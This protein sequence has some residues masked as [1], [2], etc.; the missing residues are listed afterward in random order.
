MIDV[1][2]LPPPR[3]RNSTATTR[4]STVTMRSVLDDLDTQTMRYYRR[5][6]SRYDLTWQNIDANVFFD[7][8]V[9][10]PPPTPTLTLN[11]QFQMAVRQADWCA[12]RG[13]NLGRLNAM[14]AANRLR[15]QIIQESSTSI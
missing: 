1:A 9:A 2:N 13:D 4:N 14:S 10:P 6:T 15:R 11:E 7:V 12:Q 8:P 5:V 3:V